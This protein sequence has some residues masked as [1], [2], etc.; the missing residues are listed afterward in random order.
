MALEKEKQRVSANEILQAIAAGD[1]IKLHNC[2]I[3]GELDIQRLFAE[4]EH[5]DTGRLSLQQAD[6]RAVLTLTSAVALDSC[7]F[8]ENVCFSPPWSD[9]E[10]LSVVFNADVILNSSVFCGQTRFASAVFKGQAGFD[11]CTFEQVASFRK[12]VFAGNA[13]FR[14][15]TFNGYC[16]LNEAR[17]HVDARFSNTHFAK[18]V[19]FTDVNFQAMAD[20]AGVYSAS[21]LVPMYEGVHFARCTYGDDETFWRFIKRTAQESGHYHLAGESFYNERCAY[22]WRKFRGPGYETLPRLKKLARHLTGIRLLPELVFGRWLFGYGERPARVL[23]ASLLV[24]V[25][26]ALFYFAFG[27][28]LY[29]GTTTAGSFLQSLYFSTITFTTLGFGDLHPEPGHL[30]RYI[31]MFE[32]LAGACLMALFVVSLA[33]RYSRG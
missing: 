26:C 27:S 28:V 2:T 13:M 19:N 7:T 23:T 9:P 3:S 22:L 21:R 10:G 5:F 1:D 31:A 18:G 4:T 11:G 20:F 16:L 25:L 6:G 30:T 17:F 33:K 29:R 8:E 12:T 32:A 14:T 24:I 15:V